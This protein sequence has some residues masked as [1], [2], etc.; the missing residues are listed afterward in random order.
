VSENKRLITVVFEVVNQEKMQ[1]IYESLI[2]GRPVL[3]MIPKIICNGDQVSIPGSVVAELSE[4]DPDFSN[5]NELND[6]VVRSE[7]HMK[8]GFK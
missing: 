4:I 1:P 8:E 6:L 3:G 2:S 7:K 5:R